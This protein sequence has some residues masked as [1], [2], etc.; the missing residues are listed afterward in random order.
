MILFKKQTLNI[1]KKRLDTNNKSCNYALH[2]LF[3]ITYFTFMMC[4]L[5]NNF[6]KT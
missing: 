2:A 5:N 6:I 1:K 3:A 4:L